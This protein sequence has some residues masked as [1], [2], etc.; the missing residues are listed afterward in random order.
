ML[1]V[2]SFLPLPLSIPPPSLSLCLSSHSRVAQIPNL[3]LGTPAYQKKSIY[4][5][6]L[7]TEPSPKP[8]ELIQNPAKPLSCPPP[9]K[10]KNNPSPTPRSSIYPRCRLAPFD[11]FQIWEKASQSQEVNNPPLYYYRALPLAFHSCSVSPSTA[12]LPTGAGAGGA[13][14][15]TQHKSP[16]SERAKERGGGGGW[17]GWEK[18]QR[19]R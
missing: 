18:R 2:S 14:C 4:Y 10:K 13:N 19:E 16:Q 3:F 1:S 11:S 6:P 15:F 7:G 17:G 9:A 5:H 12:P 8:T